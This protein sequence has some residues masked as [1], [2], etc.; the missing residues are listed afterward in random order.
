M[1]TVTIPK[2]LSLGPT[3]GVGTFGEEI[4]ADEDGPA[5]I[6]NIIDEIGCLGEV[7]GLRKG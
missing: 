5:R 4:N 7:R 1:D 3:K 2:L 6:L